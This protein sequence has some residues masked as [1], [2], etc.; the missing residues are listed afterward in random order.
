MLAM[1]SHSPSTVL[2]SSAGGVIP[3]PTRSLYGSTKG[4]ALLLYQA[5]SIEHPDIAFSYVIPGTIEGDF[6]ASAVDGGS[7]R[8]NAPNSVGLKREEV[9]RRVVNAVDWGERTVWMPGVYRWAHAMYWVWP[10]FVEWRAR[11]KYSFSR[12]EMTRER[13]KGTK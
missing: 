9:A 13:T 10:S 4:A 7:A 2:F 1:T 8:E 12:D 5:L 11:V 6:R 3:A